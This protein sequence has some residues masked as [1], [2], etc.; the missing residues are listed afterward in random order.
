[1]DVMTALMSGLG[2]S[3]S[4]GLNAY[5]PLL[6]VSLT[7]K[8]FP[9]LITLSPQFRFITEPWFIAVVG[10]FLVIEV[11]ADKIPMVDHANDVIGTLVRPAAGALLFAV[12][13]GAITNLDPKLAAVAGLLIAGAAHGAK[14]SARPIVTA[15][16]AGLGNPVVSTAEDVV[17]FVTSVVAILAPL[18]IGIAAIMFAL[19]FLYWLSRRS[20][21]ARPARE[22]GAGTG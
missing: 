11:V 16:T 17:A 9:Q 22:D 13:T 1:M 14:A 19:M 15:T 8:F 4:A 2:L 18:L 20:G 3:A 21:N 6:L 12:S 5:I 7:A 10:L